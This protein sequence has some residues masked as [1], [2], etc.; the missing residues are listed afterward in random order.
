MIIPAVL[1]RKEAHRHTFALAVP[2]ILSNVTIPLLG[3]VD[4]AVIGHLSDAYY[5]GGVAVG[6]MIITFLFWILGFLRMATTG[7]VAQHFGRGDGLAQLQVLYQAALMALMLALGLLLLQQPILSLALHWI[8][9][10]AEVQYYAAEY[11]NNRIWSAPAALLNLAALGYLLGRQQPR[12]A[13]VLLI[14]TNSVNIVLDIWFV[15]GLDWGV[16][17]AA[18]ASVIADYAALFTAA[19]LIWRQLPAELKQRASWSLLSLR[20]AG[21]LVALNRD[22]FLR[23]L[24]LQLCMLFVT[25]QGA[26]MGDEIVAANS[27]LMNF[28][29][30]IA[31][32]LDGFAYSAEAEVGKAV[33]A[34]AP[35]QLADAVILG[36]FW[37]ALTA[38]L[39]SGVFAL[40][41][42]GIIGLLTDIPEVRDT[43]ATY[44]PWVVLY[45]LVAFTCFLFDGVY[46]GAAKGAV[47]RNAMLLSAVGFFLFW[48]LLSPWQNHGLWLAFNGFLLLRS[49]TLA[50][51]FGWRWHQRRW[52][53]A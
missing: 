2:M 5:L 39:F 48:A 25:A 14:L 3:L 45:P 21:A 24:C 38:L 8:G 12:A 44:L 33:G 50:L 19:W 51:H 17:G 32:A 29:L 53:P 46:I 1:R 20:G 13:M 16:A 30:L 36:W 23:T 7:L 9:G 34:K 37:S 10:S 31:Y 22:I 41:G 28:T 35:S 15:I 40:A 49:L 4:T 18:R 6:A 26:R 52:L 42:E 43:A 47:M 27:V 11:F